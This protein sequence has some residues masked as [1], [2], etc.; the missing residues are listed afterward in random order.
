M[1]H[2]EPHVEALYKMYTKSTP[3]TPP[4]NEF[5]GFKLSILYNVEK[6]FHT[7]IYV[8]ELINDKDYPCHLISRSL[9]RYPDAFNLNL[10]KTHF[11]YIHNLSIYTRSYKCKKCDKLWHRFCGLDIHEKTCEI[12]LNEFFRVGANNISKNARIGY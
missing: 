9:C 7:N 11:S 12:K 3:D 2:L 10:Y 8:Y 4:M 6:I 1:Y 5:T